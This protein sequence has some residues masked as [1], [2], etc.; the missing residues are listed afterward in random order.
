MSGAQ[1]PPPAALAGR[2]VAG[3]DEVGRGPLAGPVVAAAV[4]LDAAR[5]VDGLADSKVLTPARR[6]RLATL[7]RERALAWALG[8]AEAAEIDALDI[9]RASLIAMQRAVVALGITP[10]IVLVDGRDRPRLDM[11]VYAI[12]GGDRIVPAISAASIV[13]KVARD[14]E[15]VAAH[16]EYPAYGFDRHKGYPTRAH[17][18]ALGRHGP[19]PLHRRTFSPVRRLGADPGAGEAP[20]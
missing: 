13:A 3:V 4:V 6:E 19:C 10:E 15:M 14:A 18:E 5:P 17:R 12:V 9:L 7:I 1:L 11:S 2:V 8:R 16:A 20:A